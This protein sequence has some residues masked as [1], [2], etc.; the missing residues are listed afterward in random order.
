VEE[1]PGQATSKSAAHQL[2]WLALCRNIC[3]SAILFPSPP[4]E[5][6]IHL[7]QFVTWIKRSGLADCYCGAAFRL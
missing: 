5:H 6:N 3:C 2:Q 1:T 4:G 7:F